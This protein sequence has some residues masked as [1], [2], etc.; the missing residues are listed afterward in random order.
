MK[1]KQYV[2]TQAEELGVPIPLAWQLFQ[3]LGPRE[4][5]DGFI[6]E[7]QELADQ[8]EDEEYEIE[9]RR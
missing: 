3:L 1:W 6:Y 5:Y 7:L 9:S 4:A 8:L 2:R